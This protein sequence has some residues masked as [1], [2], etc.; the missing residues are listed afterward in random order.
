MGAHNHIIISKQVLIMTM[1][2]RKLIVIH[3]PLIFLFMGKVVS[4]EHSIDFNLVQDI[5][6]HRSS[7]AV[8]GKS[9]KVQ[10]VK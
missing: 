8:I 4:L 3:L 9:D 10:L 5:S 1:I 6:I 7:S 2:F